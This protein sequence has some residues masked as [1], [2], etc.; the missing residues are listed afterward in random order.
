VRVEEIGT[1]DLSA[2]EWLAETGAVDRSSSAYVRWAQQSLNRILGLRLAVDGRVGPQTRSA[3]RSF[4]QQAKIT[5][6]GKLGPQTERAL[7]AAGAPAPPGGGGQPVPPRAPSP[8]PPGPPETTC[9]AGGGTTTDRCTGGVPKACPR[10]PNLLCVSSIA[11]VPFEYVLQ[12]GVTRDPATGLKVVT[13]RQ[14]NRTQKFIPA[15]REHLRNFLAN[16]SS[17]GMPVDAILTLGSYLCRCQSNT[18]KLS[19]HSWGDAI[20]V[21]GVRWR[22]RPPGAL[23]DTVIHNFG[24]GNAS[25]ELL[26]RRIDACLRLSFATV[27][28]YTYNRDHE[29]HY[30]CDTNRGQGPRP[31]GQTT[32]GFVQDAFTKVLGRT[33][34]ITRKL[35]SATQRALMEFSGSGSEI[36]ADESRLN[37]VLQKLFRRVAAGR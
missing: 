32:I 37:T 15:V 10:V 28:D 18:D 36:F 17:F 6:D 7:R 29:S 20:D 16:M 9:A 35:D 25:E 30:H 14:A 33:V 5:V 34:P 12:G 31:R 2:G 4:Q 27:I 3:V 26:I 24:S 1:T 23:A 22:G 13:K 21:V 11:G 19:N 8:A